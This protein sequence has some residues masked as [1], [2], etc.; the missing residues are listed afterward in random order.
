MGLPVLDESAWGKS[1]GLDPD[2]PPYPL[3]RHLLDTAAMAVHLWD[4]YLSENQRRA[5]ASSLTCSFEQARGVVALCAGLHDIGKISGFQFC[6]RH[7]KDHLSETFLADVGKIG[8]ER[9]SHDVAG[10]QAASAVLEALGFEDAG[11]GSAVRRIAEIVGG[12]HGRFYR[13]DYRRNAQWAV[14]ELL[15]GRTWA[16]QRQLHAQAVHRLLREPKVP[17]AFGAGVAVLVTGVVILADWLVSQGDYV[18]GRQRRLEGSLEDHFLRSQADAPA[19]L[20]D[21][22]LEPVELAYQGFSQSYGIDGAPNPL[23]RSVM[24]ELPAAAK[25]GRK[26]GILLVTAAPGDGKSE[27]A[28]EAVRVLSQIFHTRG[29][30]FLLP[31]M[32]T[33]DQMY[34][35][36]AGSLRRQAAQGAGLTLTH[37]MAW[38]NTAYTDED[39]E[40]GSEVLVCDGDE[41]RASA[42]SEAGLRPRRWLRGM[43][44]ALLA[45]FAVGTV[46]Q[47]LMSVLP[48]RHNALRLLALSGKAFVVDEAHAYDPYMQVLLGRLLNWLGTF[49]VPVVLLSATLPA[50]VSNRLIKEYLRGAG[51]KSSELKK[52]EFPAPYPGWLYVDAGSGACTPIS[53]ER[54]QE[55]A[56]ERRMGLR[57]QIEPVVHS[58][59][60]R[61]RGRLAVIERLLEPVAV[62]EGGCALVVCNTVGE[63]QQTYRRLQEHYTSLTGQELLLV[64]ARFPGDVREERTALV[65]SGMGRG[66]PRPTRRIV[67]ATQVVEQSLDLDA[68]IVISDLAPLALLLQRAGRCWRH[69]NWWSRH[70]YPGGRGRPGWADAP[71]LVVLDPLVGGGKVPVQWGEVYAE[72][73]LIQTSEVMAELDGRQIAIPGDVQDLV[74]RVHGD[75]A[76]RFNWDDPAKSAAWSAYRGGEMAA[77]GMADVV[78]VPRAQSLW[79]LHQ[80]HHLEGTED[81]WEAATRL[82]ADSVRLLCVHQQQDGRLTLDVAGQEQLP[83][84]D[85]EPTP[86]DVRRVMRRTIP[87]RVDW[88]AGAEADAHQPPASW[89]THPMLG[90]LRILRQSVVHGLAQEARVGTKSLRLDAELGLVRE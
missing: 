81:E 75:R 46:D 60:A 7:G 1:R 27:T 71:R 47:A 84:V 42:R 59:K 61:A 14:Q 35:R 49:G 66:G 77:R 54:Q 25:D 34:G 13:N 5:I 11:E 19:L 6:S 39:L 16:L 58:A 87:V 30:A 56:A 38:L 85:A 72:Y 67:V 20:R 52:R 12:H 23:Q 68:D 24:E 9:V 10:M 48:V 80:M 31:T 40:G 3:V 37:S 26:G 70:G 28:L 41:N 55:Q 15:G 8:V 62:G 21:A 65:T 83:A 51:M 33:S 36:V 53:R 45:Q 90:D 4:V 44:R 43:K 73:L 78:V 2:S 18:R 32:A 50:S 89:S 76:D 86:S 57:V 79:E 17:D 22:G 29:Y 74:E 63:A 82:G 88:F 69:E 64:H